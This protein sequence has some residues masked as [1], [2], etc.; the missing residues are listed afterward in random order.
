[1]ELTE[2]ALREPVG[3]D[4]RRELAGCRRIVADE[5]EPLD[6]GREDHAVEAKGAVAPDV[7]ANPFVEEGERLAPTGREHHEVRRQR[8]PRVE[9]DRGAANEAA[10]VSTD[11][12]DAAGARELV[13]AVRDPDALDPRRERRVR[14]ELGRHAEEAGKQAAEASPPCPD[15]RL[16]DSV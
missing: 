13:D 12:A 3:R 6:V 11:G 7:C 9:F 10:E 1:M 14:D 8:L 16:P 5:T 15:E 4:L 2:E